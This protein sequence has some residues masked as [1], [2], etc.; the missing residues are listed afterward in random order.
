MAQTP[1]SI[2]FEKIKESSD[3]TLKGM[4]TQGFN[5][6]VVNNPYFAAGGGL[7]LLGTGLALARLGVVKGSG[8]IYRQSNCSRINLKYKYCNPTPQPML[9]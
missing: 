6:I 4:L 3:G 2:D 7:M 1:Q 9:V 5:E 8:F